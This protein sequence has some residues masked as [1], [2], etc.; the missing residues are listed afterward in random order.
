MLPPLDQK[1]QPRFT[2]DWFS[3]NIPIWEKY[4]LPFA[5]RKRFSV[6]EVGSWEGRSACF[7][8]QHVLT[9]SSAT[10]TCVDTWGGCA[11]HN[12]GDVVTEV[13]KTFDHN[14]KVVGGT[15]KVTKVKGP[16]QHV[17]RTLPL[18]AYDLVYIDASHLAPNVLTDA[19]LCFDLLKSEG[20]LILDDYLWKSPAHD[21]NKPLLEPKIAIDTFLMIFKDHLRVL[22][23]GRQVVL[24]KLSSCSV[25]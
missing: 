7:L 19:V 21:E 16:S 5:G 22:H 10:L 2:H 9:H 23:K 14:I 8:L 24:T 1:D 6:L 13:E 3:K 12:L 17:L 18:E 4:V 11:H 15:R 25:S 20:M